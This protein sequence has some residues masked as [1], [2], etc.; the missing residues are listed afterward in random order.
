MKKLSEATVKKLARSLPGWRVVG[1][2]LRR[3]YRFDDYMEGVRFF[4]RVAKL[5]EKMY[6]HPDVAISFGRVDISITTHDAGGLTRR[7]FKLA[8]LIQRLLPQAK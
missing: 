1:R 2:R 5:A 4:N 6:H 7:D 8:G 3:T